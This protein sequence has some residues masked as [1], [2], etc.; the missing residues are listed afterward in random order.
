MS[1]L[2]LTNKT[3]FYTHS[4]FSKYFFFFL[5]LLKLTG[6]IWAIFTNSKFELFSWIS[7]IFNFSHGWFSSMHFLTDCFQS[8]QFFL[9]V[10]FLFSLN[11]LLFPIYNWLLEH[12][13]ISHL[14]NEIHAFLK[15]INKLYAKFYTFQQNV[16][17]FRSSN[18][19]STYF[20]CN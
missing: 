8:M 9:S 11:P 7:K 14:I 15:L 20:L 5:W 17:F 18:F 3:F 13:I 10:I 19:Q 6:E 16:H 4:Q 12:M 1:I 2:P